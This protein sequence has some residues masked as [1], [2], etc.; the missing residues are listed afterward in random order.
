MQIP[1]VL[2]NKIL[3]FFGPQGEQWLDKLPGLL[4]ECTAKWKLTQCRESEV[5]SYNYVCFAYSPD[6][7][8]VALKIGIP[9]PE[10]ITEMTALNLYAGRNICRCFE[11]DEVLGAMLLERIIPGIDLTEIACSQERIQAAAELVS[12]LPIP[13]EQDYGLPSWSELAER[14]F[15]RLRAENT[16]GEKMLRLVD[17]AEELIMQLESSGRPK[18]LLHGDLNHW[19]ILKSETGWKAID[20]KG[21]IGVACMEAGRFMLNEL[22]LAAPDNPVQ[23]MEEMTEAF[24]AKLGEPRKIIALAA[25]L[26][27]A[28]STS[29]KFEEHGRRDYTADVDEC[30]FLLDYYN[31]LS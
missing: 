1:K 14:T 16:C 24:S 3:R 29:W 7:G 8:E 20:P 11:Q 21:Q 22:E 27:K 28:L 25:F 9:H 5:M 26:D 30:Q 18:I 4:E 31:Q 19:N 15:G 6:Y 23:L 12:K 17:R 13:L 10:L 2:R